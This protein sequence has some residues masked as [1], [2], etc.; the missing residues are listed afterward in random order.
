MTKKDFTADD[1]LLIS[2]L[3]GE[4][5]TADRGAVEQRLASDAD[6]RG[7]LSRL[8]RAW[9]ALDLLPRTGLDPA[10]TSSTMSMLALTAEQ[11]S[12]ATCAR[13]RRH[14]LP[15]WLARGTPGLLLCAAA[16]LLAALP[17]LALK[18]SRL[19]DLPVIQNLDLYRYGDSIRFLRLLDQSQLLRPETP[20]KVREVSFHDLNL[21]VR[22]GDIQQALDRMTPGELRQLW[23]LRERFR[24]LSRAEQ[25]SLRAFHRELAQDENR[26]RLY[27]VLVGYH[28]WLAGLTASER[29]A[30]MEL[31]PEIRLQEMQN[32]QRIQRDLRQSPLWMDMTPRDLAHLRDWMREF[33][34]RHQQEILSAVPEPQRTRVSR[35]TAD[36]WNFAVLAAL[37]F[38]PEAKLPVPSD[39]E[40]HALMEGLSPPVRDRL[41]E[42]IRLYGAGSLIRMA[43]QAMRRMRENRGRPFPGFPPG[44]PPPPRGPRPEPP[45]GPGVRMPRPPEGGPR[46]ERMGRRMDDG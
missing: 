37:Q 40:V 45:P 23:E 35:V 11:E 5:S 38:V 16:F 10:F 6:F 39:T 24:R 15:G 7:Q 28:D 8:Q 29:A 31:P 22:E 9:E 13:A 17:L 44:E 43:P 25:G 33:L 32:I 42:Q 14:W 3:D 36:G 27:R 20:E 19:R 26:N 1:E 41:Q 21:A 12:L 34:R 30:L 4:L 18:R 2:Y 46:R